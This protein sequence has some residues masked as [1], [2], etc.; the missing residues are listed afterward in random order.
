MVHKACRI[1]HVHAFLVFGVGYIQGC[2]SVASHMPPFSNST[3][4]GKEFHDFCVFIE[5]NSSQPC[6]QQDQQHKFLRDHTP[7]YT[8]PKLRRSIAS[9]P[10]VLR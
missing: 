1:V 5:L 10:K 6:D 2:H 9:R 3:G 4:P 8:T 7:M